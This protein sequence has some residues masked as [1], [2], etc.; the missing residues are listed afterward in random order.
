MIENSLLNNTS[1]WGI[2]TR[3]GINLVFLVIL[4]GVVYYRFSKKEKF[5]FTF[6]LIGIIV[7][8]VSSIMK[9][10]DIGVGMAFGLFAIFGILRLRTINFSVKDM[11]YLF[12]TIGISVINALGLLIYHFY[13][14]IIFNALIIL[15]AFIL[16]LFIKSKSYK[17][18]TIIYENIS[19]LRP[20]NHD[21]LIH[22]LSAKTGLNV[23]KTKVLE[24]NLKS[25]V[26]KLDIYYK[27]NGGKRQEVPPTPPEPPVQPAQ[28]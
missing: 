21:S 23:I 26:A 15:I 11:A 3:F 28:Q 22:D 2:L 10:F 13:G 18:G 4:I 25:G 14:I 7:F 6:F 24:L 20:E 27:E 17:K 1:I 9:K 5:M 12:A 8:F 19:L 16:E